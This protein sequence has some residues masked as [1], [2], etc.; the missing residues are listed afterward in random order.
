MKSF[1]KV[2]FVANPKAGRGN[3]RKKLPELFHV[4]GITTELYITQK[5]GDA[6]IAAEEASEE[7]FDLVVAI[8]GDGTV[9]EIA[10][11]LLGSSTTL[12]IIPRGSGNGLA[13][14]L[15]IPFS[16]E[17]FKK[18]IS[19]S[20]TQNVD[21]V[22]INDQLSLNIS[23]IGLDGRVA[24]EFS[25][26][27][28]RGLQSYIKAT[29]KSLKKAKPFEIEIQTNGNKSYE[30]ALMVCFANSSQHGNDFIIN[31]KANTCDGYFELCILKE[32]SSA[33]V[34][35]VLADVLLKRTPASRYFRILKV[36]EAQIMAETCS[37]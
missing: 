3:W 21:I 13:R 27:E 30:R 29:L 17:G 31:P 1:Q 32:F 10:I 24:N 20:Q 34:P 36:K 19:Q 12:G 28:G 14:H 22:R 4:E 35:L 25:K 6:R 2:L 33:H 26:M 7:G 37:Y 8:G 23:G 11:G 15:G 9:N 18:S 16:W 5:P